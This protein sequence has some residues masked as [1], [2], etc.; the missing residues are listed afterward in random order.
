[1]SIEKGL[2]IENGIAVKYSGTEEEVKLPSEVI[3]IAP[4]AF[5]GCK[6]LK[7]IITPPKLASIGKG[8][9][10]GCD[11]FGGSYYSRQTLSKSARRQGVR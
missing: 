11:K 2:R 3:R 10:Y 4:Y 1:M 7:R 5:Y 9:F 6:T 8:A